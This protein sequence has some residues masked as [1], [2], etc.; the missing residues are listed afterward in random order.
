MNGCNSE[1]E[2]DFHPLYLCPV[3]LRKLVWNLQ[4]EPIPYLKRL[5]AFCRKQWF[6]EEYWYGKAITAL[7]G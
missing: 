1:E 7:Q 2:R 4:V 6:D 3:C 5:E